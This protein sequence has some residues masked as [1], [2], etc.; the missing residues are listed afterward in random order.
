MRRSI[1]F[2]LALLLAQPSLYSQTLY[3][4]RNIQEAYKKGTRSL[5]G[6][7]GPNYWQ[8]KG[9]YTIAVTVA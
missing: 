2:C 5:D 6:R 1:P 9:R 3:T 8:N 7:P 4:P